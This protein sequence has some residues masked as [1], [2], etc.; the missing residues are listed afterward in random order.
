[1]AIVHAEPDAKLETLVPPDEE[2]EG[3]EAGGMYC[4]ECGGQLMPRIVEQYGNLFESSEELLVCTGD[5]NN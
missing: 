2:M 1:M 3:G 5:H 4:R